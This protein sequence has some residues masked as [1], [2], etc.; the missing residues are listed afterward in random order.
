MSNEIELFID[1][2]SK[3]ISLEVDNSSKE[4]SLEI[5][6]S[7]KEISLEVDNSSKEI[8]LEVDKSSREISLEIHYLGKQGPQ[9][10]TG[11]TG[12]TGPQGEQGVPGVGVAEGGTTGQFL[13]K[14]SNNDYD[15]EWGDETD[16]AFTAWESSTGYLV[17]GDNVSELTNDAEYLTEH[18]DLSGY[19]QLSGAT[20]TG[21][22]SATNLSG[23]NTGDQDLS[24]LVEE[25]PEDGNQYVRQDG[26]WE[27]VSIPAGTINRQISVTF[28]GGGFVPDAGSIAYIRVPYSGTITGWTITS[29]IAGSCVL[30]V[31]KD[32]YANY[33]PTVADTIA[34]T[35]KPTLTAVAKNE[36]LTLTTWT[37]AI[38]AGDFIAVKIDSASTLTRINLAIHVEASN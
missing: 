12:A 16:P 10:A 7:S 29:N 26:D 6:N 9:G 30:D 21:D 14:A 18:Q 13:K 27:E 3:E 22:I 25:A 37:T 5:D 35:E 2:T 11:D 32:T 28:D 33:P 19:A 36:D 1:N 15:T 24:G 38:T 17:S 4:I 8:S 20:F 23:A 31:W 34:G